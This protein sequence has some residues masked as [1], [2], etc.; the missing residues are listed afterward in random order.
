VVDD[1]GGGL[2]IE[3]H[4]D[5]E[6]LEREVPGHLQHCAGGRGIEAPVGVVGLA[7]RRQERVVGA[8]LG[9]RTTTRRLAASEEKETRNTQRPALHE[10]PSIR[11]RRGM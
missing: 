9:G 7:I 4:V 8:V 11:P 3:A 6:D 10:I 1:A 2:P 5:V